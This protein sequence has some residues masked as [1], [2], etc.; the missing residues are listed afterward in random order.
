METLRKRANTWQHS[1]SADLGPVSSGPGPKTHRRRSAS[2]TSSGAEFSESPRT[3]QITFGLS[4]GS[5]CVQV[6]QL[7]TLDKFRKKIEEVTQISRRAQRIIVNSSALCSDQDHMLLYDIAP[8]IFYSDTVDVRVLRRCSDSQARWLDLL[9]Q[10][11]EIARAGLFSG[12]ARDLQERSDYRRME[13]F[14]NVLQEHM[15]NDAHRYAFHRLRV[16]LLHERCPFGPGVWCSEVCQWL[17]ED[18]NF[19]EMAL[20]VNT[21]AAEVQTPI[22]LYGARE[23]I[24]S[25]PALAR[26]LASNARVDPLVLADVAPQ[27]L[28]DREFLLISARRCGAILPLAPAEMQQD[29]ELVLTCVAQT[30]GALR[31][32]LPELKDNKEIVLRAV[33]TSGLAL[34]HA[35]PKLRDDE[36]VVLK[37][38]QGSGLALE[39][40]SNRLR[41]QRGIV[42]MAVSQDGCA[43]QF[44]A[45]ELRDDQEVVKSAV[46]VSGQALKHVSSRLQNVQEV[47]ILAAK[48]HPQALQHASPELRCDRST[49]MDAVS[50]SFKAFEF[51]GHDLRADSQVIRLAARQL[52]ATHGLQAADEELPKVIESNV[53]LVSKEAGQ[54]LLAALQ[55]GLL[56][57][58]AFGLA[59]V[60]HDPQL[61]RRLEEHVK[62]DAE[63]SLEAVRRLPE[64][65]LDMPFQARNQ[66]PIQIAAVAQRPEMISFVLPT[67]VKRVLAAVEKEK[68]EKVLQPAALVLESS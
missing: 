62:A 40:A 11:D 9:E 41:A 22:L 7:T 64:L 2:S 1:D 26:Q 36:E 18:E 51:A 60:K 47:V 33:Q 6:D 53:L 42:L 46:Q 20:E 44:A 23:Q 48:R 4:D 45:T 19:L 57:T 13:R 17:A 43:I 58:R 49:V 8:E 34:E 38:V 3:V 28:Q 50:A 24:Q 31:F 65:F 68:A 67:D 35:S 56:T 66:L 15:M 39:F 10:G 25:K 55:T 52:L 29:L 54:H 14:R 16:H 27:V 63:V 59:V 61:Y 5:A 21:P 30:G 32:V 12:V 37:A